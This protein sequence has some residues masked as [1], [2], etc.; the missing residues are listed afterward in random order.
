MGGRH[1]NPNRPPRAREGRCDLPGIDEKKEIKMKPISNRQFYLR[2]LKRD[3]RSFLEAIRFCIGEVLHPFF[4]IKWM[5]KDIWRIITN[6][7]G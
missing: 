1:L 2:E 7:C 5:L 3:A 6:T 4:W